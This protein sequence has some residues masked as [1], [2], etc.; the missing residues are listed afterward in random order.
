[1]AIGE[2]K[3]LICFTATHAQFLTEFFVLNVPGL[4]SHKQT[5]H[6]T[7][8]ALLAPPREHLLT[9]SSST[10]AQSFCLVFPVAMVIG[11]RFSVSTHQ[12]GVGAMDGIRDDDGTAEATIIG[13]ADGEVEG[14]I[15]GII[16]GA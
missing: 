11:K 16:D 12:T 8:H 7:G 9:V 4:S 10:H 14:T 5:P 3:H 1:M 15:D 6:V 2:V 13:P